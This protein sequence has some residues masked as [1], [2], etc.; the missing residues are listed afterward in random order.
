MRS[1]EQWRT[2][3]HNQ[4][5]RDPSKRTEAGN[6]SVLTNIKVV[7]NLFVYN[8][9]KVDSIFFNISGSLHNL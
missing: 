5:I 6:A 7:I 1:K 4:K 9:R 8:P 2:C 3:F